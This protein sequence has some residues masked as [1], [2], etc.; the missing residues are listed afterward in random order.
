MKK[1]IG[2]HCRKRL[3]I[4]L[5]L[6][7]LLFLYICA[8]IEQ[9]TNIFILLFRTG[10]DEFVMCIKSDQPANWCKLYK[11]YNTF[12]SEI[13]SL[14]APK[15]IRK[16]ISETEWKEAESNLSNATDRDGNKINLN[17]VGLSCGIFIPY[18]NKRRINDW[19]SV[20]DTKALERA[21]QLVTKTS[22][23]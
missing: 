7:Y 11:F 2:I 20:T 5:Y 8:R 22:K 12:K 21:K 16:F 3:C 4:G 1:K 18:H 9:Y 6:F 23:D 10:G 14:G 13:N 17:I 15:C 19:L